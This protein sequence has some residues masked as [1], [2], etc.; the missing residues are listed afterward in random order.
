[1][2]SAISVTIITKASIFA[3]SKTMY[4]L[5]RKP[6]K[7]FNTTVAGP[8]NM[9]NYGLLCPKNMVLEAVVVCSDATWPKLC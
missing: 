8:G 9:I 7:V 2:W 1:M 3:L 4:L 5:I 6:N